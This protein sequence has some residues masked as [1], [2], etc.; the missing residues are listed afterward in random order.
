MKLFKETHSPLRVSYDFT[1][2]DKRYWYYLA[3]LKKKYTFLGLI[4]VYRILAARLH[5]ADRM[6][7]QLH[8]S[9]RMRTEMR[10]NGTLLAAQWNISVQLEAAR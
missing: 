5:R 3:V 6:G 10:A 8:V 4:P 1:T 7:S 9:D 2:G